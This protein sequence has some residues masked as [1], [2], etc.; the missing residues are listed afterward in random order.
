MS[1]RAELDYKLEEGESI[2]IFNVF[3]ESSKLNSFAKI[4]TIIHIHQVSQYVT[5]IYKENVNTKH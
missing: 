2:C 4:H 3:V 1:L 5:V